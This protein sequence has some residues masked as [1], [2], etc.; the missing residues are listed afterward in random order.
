MAHPTHFASHDARATLRRRPPA[1]RCAA[2]GAD[3]AARTLAPVTVTG[4]A[5]PTAGVAGF[6]D[7]PL[8]SA[9]LQAT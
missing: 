3:A 8:R 5:P 4:R 1:R 7:V 6:G 9:P 2:L